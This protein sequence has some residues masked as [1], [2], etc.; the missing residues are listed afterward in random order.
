MDSGQIIFI[1]SGLF[2]G[3]AA[4]FFAIMLWSKT[5]DIAWMLMVIG[6]IAAYIN[7]VH[8][9]LNEFGIIETSIFMIGSHTLASI[10]LPNLPSVFFIAAFLIMVIRKYR[11]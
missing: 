9:I 10:V 11:R 3:A 8:S 2:L 7:T 5:R 6:T 1:S 4:A